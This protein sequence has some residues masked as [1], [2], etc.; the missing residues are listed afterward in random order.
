MCFKAICSPHFKT[1]LAHP[2]DKNGFKCF[3]NRPKFELRPHKKCVLKMEMDASKVHPIAKISYV[4]L[5]FFVEFF[6]NFT[7]TSATRCT[8]N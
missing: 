1:P 5:E 2:F 6:K 8:M 3:V 7:R 4:I